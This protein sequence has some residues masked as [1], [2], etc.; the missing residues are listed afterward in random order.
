MKRSICALTLVL[1]GIS[2]TAFAQ[3]PSTQDKARE[4]I[5]ALRRQRMETLRRVLVESGVPI[6]SDAPLDERSLR[7]YLDVLPQ[8]H[9]ARYETKPLKGVYIAD[10][11]YLP[12]HVELASDTVIIA[13][14]MVFEGNTVMVKGQHS[15]NLFTTYPTECLGKTVREM[16]LEAGFP[17]LAKG[18]A[19][20]V[21]MELVQRL[22]LDPYRNGKRY[23]QVFAPGRITIDVSGKPGRPGESAMSNCMP[24]SRC[25]PADWST[26]PGNFGTVPDPIKH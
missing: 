11:L 16:L 7:Q 2:V 24:T 18:A 5:R 20:P 13:D 6:A 8:M 12:E 22:N 9:E 19:P 23:Q 1:V 21:F 10:T 14:H 15:V 25:D 26:A 17:L 3:S 4:K